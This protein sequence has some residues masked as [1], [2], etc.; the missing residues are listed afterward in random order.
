MR[1]L[2]AAVL[3]AFALSAGA[4]TPAAPVK[5]EGKQTKWKKGER[6]DLKAKEWKKQKSGLEIWDVSVG[7]GAAVKPGGTVKVHYIGWLTDEKATVFDSSV[8]RGEPI[9]F[10]LGQVIKGWQEGIPGMKPGG[11]RLLKIP[12]ELAYGKRGAGRAVP[13]DATL[14]FEVELL[15]AK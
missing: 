14:V 6:P 13:P 12:P 15:E 10:G 3:A 4:P 7:K 9:E 5:E 2:S 1:V 11:I 8:K